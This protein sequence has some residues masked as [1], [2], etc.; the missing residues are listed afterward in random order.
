MRADLAASFQHTAIRHLEQRVRR[1]MD[2]CEKK[3][4]SQSSSSSSQSLPANL[5]SE[6]EQQ[7]IGMGIDKTT[8][9]IGS[10]P[11]DVSSSM[12]KTLPEEN[13]DEATSHPHAPISTEAGPSQ[14][15]EVLDRED[16]DE[17]RRQQGVWSI[18]VVGG[19]AANQ[20]LRRRLQVKQKTRAGASCF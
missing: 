3:T 6:G 1:A 13:T 5:S 7:H 20:E 16:G 9:T 19:V 2:I 8:A 18:A 10:V 11:D 4:K 14:G 12:S 15:G 17:G